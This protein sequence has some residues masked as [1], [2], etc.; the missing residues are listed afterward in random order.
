LEIFAA[1]RSCLIYAFLFAILYLSL[2]S[3]SFLLISSSF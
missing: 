3:V 2:T 1:L